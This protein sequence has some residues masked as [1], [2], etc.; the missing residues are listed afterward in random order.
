ML[1]E[2][3]RE[4]DIR[5]IVGEELLIDRVYDLGR[6]IA[7][8]L[9]QRNPQLHTV[10]VGMDGRVHSDAIR[11]Q[12]VRALA[13]SGFDVTT[14][15]VCTSPVMYF[16]MYTRHF[17]AGIM[18]TASH[19]PKEYNGF[20]INLAKNSL[21]GDD[22]RAIRDIFFAGKYV[23]IPEE[24]VIREEDVKTPYVQWLSDNFA[25]L[26]GKAVKCVMD[27]GNGAAGSVVPQLVAAMNW[28]EVELLYEEID[29]NYPHHEA[30]PVVEK[31]MRDV[32]ALLQTTPYTLGIGFDGDCDRVGAMTKEGVLVPGDQ[33]MALFAL[34]IVKKHPDLSIVCD[35]KSSG[36]LLDILAHNNIKAVMSP[37]GHSIV[38]QAMHREGALLG[39]ELSGHFCFKDRYFGFDDGLYAALRII[40]MLLEQGKSL[41][42]AL[43]IIPVKK[44]S[45]E[46]RMPWSEH[47]KN[48]AIDAVK[49][50]YAAKADCSLITIDGVRVQ[51]PYGWGLVRASNTQPKITLR[52][53]SD[54]EEGLIALKQEFYELLKPLT[55]ESVVR[56]YLEL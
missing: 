3:F 12:L 35:I 28:S 56:E 42:D 51:T 46:Y 11:T 45:P 18:I 5:G 7:T 24:G 48:E 54:T 31:N 29:G 1:A 26:K 4:Y 49:N 20:K 9:L 40:E 13:D 44:S 17:D 32:R 34:S 33:L 43:H 22:I 37:A 15:G 25:H 16:A 38:K 23:N 8:Y 30:D 21:W 39:G 36:A 27:C 2:I 19:N 6:A 41:G 47:G 52:F 10:V 14:I 55:D 53:E 50:F